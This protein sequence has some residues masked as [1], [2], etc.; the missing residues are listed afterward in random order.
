MIRTR[1]RGRH[2]A[3]RDH[4]RLPGR[5]HRARGLGGGLAR[6][7]GHRVPRSSARRGRGRGPAP[8]VRDRR[9]H[10]R[11][12]TVPALA[13][14]QAAGA[15][16]PGDERASQRGRR[17][18]GLRRAWHRRRR[19]GIARLSDGRAH[20][21]PDPRLHAP[22][23][24]GGLQRP[25]RR[26]AADRR[27][28]RSRQDAR[29]GRPRPAGKPGRC[30]RPDIRHGGPRLE[31]ESDSRD[32]R[33]RRRHPRD[34]GRSSPSRRHHHDPPRPVATNDR[35]DRRARVRADEAVRAPRRHLAR[36][37]CRRGVAH[38]GVAVQAD[39]RRGAR[40]VRYRAAAARPPAATDGEHRRHAASRLRDRGELSRILRRRGREHPELARRP[41]I[42]PGTK[43]RRAK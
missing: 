27:D 13:P 4:R 5:R 2:E 10:A 22:H 34:Q 16:A 26:L 7:R 11:A 24:A 21:G 9:H 36:A 31:P 23:P 25:P 42:P 32:L 37:D 30:R 41:A 3:L 40:C 18:R 14:R 39:R 19:H 1:R 8:P 12:D 33:G 6:C 43:E 15:E 17:L 38:P 20:L 28:W 29:R 35:A